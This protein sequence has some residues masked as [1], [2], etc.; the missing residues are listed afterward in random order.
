MVSANSISQL[1]KGFDLIVIR[2]EN[3]FYLSNACLQVYT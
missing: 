1:L 3:V 2:A